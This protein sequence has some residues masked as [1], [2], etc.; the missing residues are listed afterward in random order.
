VIFV[1]LLAITVRRGTIDP[2][3]GMAVERSKA[4]R[5]SDNG[6]TFYFCSSECQDEFRAELSSGPEAPPA[7]PLGER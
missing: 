2:M 5:A 4:L 1:G 3:C 7:E 6:E